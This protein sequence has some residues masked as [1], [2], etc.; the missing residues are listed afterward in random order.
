MAC[1]EAPETKAE[2]VAALL[3][4]LASGV[5]GVAKSLAKGRPNGIRA[6]TALATNPVLPTCIRS[7]F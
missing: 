3:S 5:T 7:S 2:G 6:G 4:E 1:V